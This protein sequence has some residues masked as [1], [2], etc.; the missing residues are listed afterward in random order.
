M[1]R[2]T[3]PLSGHAHPWTGHLEGV[4]SKVRCVV[5][6]EQRRASQAMSW[7]ARRLAGWWHGGNGSINLDD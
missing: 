7:E 2:W 4:I 3:G 5:T 1:V 6:V